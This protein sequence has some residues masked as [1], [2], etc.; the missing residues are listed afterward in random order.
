VQP[1]APGAPIVWFGE[2]SG[3]PSYC[4]AQLMRSLLLRS[5]LFLPGLL[6][7]LGFVSLGAPGCQSKACATN[8]LNCDEV[9]DDIG[10]PVFDSSGQWVEGDFNDDKIGDGKAIDEDGNGTIDGV[11]LDTNYD[12]F[13]DSID[14][15]GDKIPDKTT[16]LGEQGSGGAPSGVG[17]SPA[18]GGAPGTVGGS[19]SGGAPNTTGSCLTPSPVHNSP[20]TISGSDEGTRYY[21]ADTYRQ[22]CADLNACPA[23]P[24][25]FIANGWGENWTSHKITFGGSIF[26]VEDFQGQRSANFGP[27]GYPS[28]FCGLYSNEQSGNCGLPAAISSLSR[29]NT[30]LRWSHTGTGSDFNVAYDVWMGN[31]N[32]FAGFLMVW[33]RDPAENQPAG[34]VKANNVTVGSDPTTFDVWTGQVNGSPIVNYVRRSGQELYEYSFDVLDFVEHAKANYNLPGDTIQSVAIGF[35]I[36][37][38]PVTNLKV[39]DFCVEVQ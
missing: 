21:K 35:E 8:D 32:T 18:A 11:G 17:G 36:W 28:M 2:G 30:G 13:I 9:P 4:Q 6:L 38:G 15:N 25:R 29:V 7:T 31:G 26:A 12:G 39:D 5:H 10:K 23:V 3:F 37:S 14:R 22:A 34:S 19:A 27:A 1:K 16:G 24:Y 20:F 33:Y